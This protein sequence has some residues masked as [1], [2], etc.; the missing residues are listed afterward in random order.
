MHR[1]GM[2]VV[3]GLAAP[4]A[5]AQPG[6]PIDWRA[7]E[8]GILANQTQLTF[9]EDFSKA[10]EAYFSPDGKWI[11]FQAVPAS[12]PNTDAPYQMYVAPL[13]RDGDGG[14]TGLGDA[15]QLSPDGSANTCGFFHPSIPH[16][17][18][19]GS[20]I[21]APRPATDEYSRGKS[22]YKWVFPEEME[23]VTRSV[24][25]IWDANH[26]N[27]NPRPERSWDVDGE[28]PVALWEEPGYDAECSYS[29]DG[30]FIVFTHVD[31]ETGDADLYIHDV[32]TQERWPL[33]Q[34][35]GYDG[36]PFF[37]PDGKRICYRSDRHQNDML[38]LFVGD[39]EFDAQGRPVGLSMEHVVTDNEDVN[40]APYFHPSGEFMIYASSEFGHFNYEV[41]SI[42]TPPVGEA[43]DPETLA[44][45]R[46]TS[47][48]GFDGLPVFSADGSL[49]MWTSQRSEDRTSQ[50]WIA[51]TVDLRP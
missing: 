14:V 45:K 47:A 19:F 20:T 15:I 32:Q 40:W 13:L 43:I 51:N 48:M 38:Q 9:A 36:G 1:S 8:A 2:F 17:V 26:A 39:L 41:I 28:R 34:A 29:P 33:V 7:E 46:I 27:A 24:P 18:I 25:E 31:P 37:S 6:A 50:I 35:P 4:C 22:R 3:V 23:V 42:A 21:V 30:R 16:K 49:M 11:I 12:E 5:L 10:G 44:T